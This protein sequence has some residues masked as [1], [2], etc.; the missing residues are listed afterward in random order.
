MLKTRIQ[1]EFE[2]GTKLLQI[3]FGDAQLSMDINL[4]LSNVIKLFSSSQ[5]GS[6]TGE[7]EPP[8]LVV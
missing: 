5:Q 7:L 2:V 8:E 1:N 4:M 3:I 6:C